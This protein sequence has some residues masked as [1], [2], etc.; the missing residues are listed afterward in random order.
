MAYLAYVGML[1]RR[2]HTYVNAY[3]ITDSIWLAFVYPLSLIINAAVR[4]FISN[5]FL[6]SY[7]KGHV[8]VVNTEPKSYRGFVGDFSIPFVI[9]LDFE[10]EEDLSLEDRPLEDDCCMPEIANHEVIL[11]HYDIGRPI[12]NFVEKL[13][14]LLII[15]MGITLTMLLFLA[16]GWRVSSLFLVNALGLEL[17]YPISCFIS[18]ILCTLYPHFFFEGIFFGFF[19]VYNGRAWRISLN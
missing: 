14:S 17:I 6:P 5:A 9:F 16:L 12:G 19:T 4:T 8:E 13:K 3:S 2:I 11:H 7:R 10:F 1:I 18:S 15:S